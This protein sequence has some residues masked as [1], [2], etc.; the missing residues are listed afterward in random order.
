[1]IND[2]AKTIAGFLKYLSFIVR[3]LFANLI[4]RKRIMIH[5][6]HVCNNPVAISLFTLPI[7]KT[8]S[9]QMLIPCERRYSYLPS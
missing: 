1:M 4:E 7:S 2:V 8:A 9:P 3:L 5:N 6:Y